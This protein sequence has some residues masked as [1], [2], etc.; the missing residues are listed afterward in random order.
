MIS[1]T[2]ATKTVLENLY[3]PKIEKLP[4]Q[5]CI[6]RVIQEKLIAD[7]DFPPF[8]RVSMDGIS[9]Q[10]QQFEKGQRSFPIEGLQAAGSPQQLLKIDGNCLEVMTGAVLP[11]NTDTVIRYEDVKMENGQATILI[12][13]IRAYQNIHKQGIDRKKGAEIVKAGTLISTAE[14]GVAATV[15]KS[16]LK[17]ATLPKTVIISTGDELV[18]IEETPLP[19]QIRKSNVHQIWAILNQQGIQADQLHLNDEKEV[20]RQQLAICLEEYDAIILSGGVSK[21]KFDFIPEVLEGL[22]VEKLFHRVQQRPGKPF[23]FGKATNGTIIFA[24]PGN[25]VSTFMCTHRYFL[26]WLRASLGLKAFDLPNAVLDSD[27]EFKPALTY[28][29]QVTTNSGKDGRLMAS[30][31]TGKGS[32]DLA[33]LVDADALLE[34]P[35][36]KR[37]FKKGEVFPLLKF[38]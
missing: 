22:K 15:G 29:L 17:V 34:L 28:F 20:I 11:E 26:P 33:N 18:N 37:Y 14:I 3:E 12:E 36:S 21:G 8:P 31:V 10:Y 6:G 24:F 30:P 4:L 25:P 13:D 7:R 19:Y 23:W 1:V 5:N 27:F 2:Q 9:I 16:H 35:D 32:G 38:R